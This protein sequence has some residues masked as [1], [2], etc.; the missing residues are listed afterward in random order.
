MILFFV[1]LHA[2][3]IVLQGPTLLKKMAKAAERD[4]LEG[5]GLRNKHGPASTIVLMHREGLDDTD[6]ARLSSSLGVRV[7]CLVDIMNSSK[8]VSISSDL[9]NLTSDTLATI[10]YTSGTTGRPKV[11]SNC[12]VWSVFTYSSLS[13]HLSPTLSPSSSPRELCCLM[14]ISFT[15]SR[16]GLHLRK[17]IM[18]LSHFQTTL[19]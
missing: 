4:G 18:I 9:P 12:N 1:Q 13:L 5:I 7:L 15:K 3:T 19:W 8:S 11:S 16:S 2:C 17:D 14:A 10:V 6:F